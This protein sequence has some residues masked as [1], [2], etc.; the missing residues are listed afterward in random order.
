MEEEDDLFDDPAHRNDVEHQSHAAIAA[1][2]P[3]GTP[4]RVSAEKKG[5][6][7]K[8]ESIWIFYIRHG[9]GS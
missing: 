1:Q 5:A 4:A 9:T 8:D 7:T 6:T 2:C 3:E